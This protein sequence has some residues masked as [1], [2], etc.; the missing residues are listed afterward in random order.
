MKV[1]LPL[2][3]VPSD[4]PSVLQS[5]FNLVPYTSVEY[6]KDPIPPV[7]G[8]DLET[9]P[10]FFCDC[11]H[12]YQSF[13]T[14]RT[15]QTR[16]DDRQCPRRLFNPQ[17]HMGYAQ[18]LT[19]NRPFFEVDISVL[20]LASDDH[21]RYPLAFRQSMPPLR[22]YSKMAIKGAEDEMNTS[23]F[24]YKERWLEYL[25]GYST[26]DILE[27]IKD[28]TPE[29][30]FGPLLRRVARQFLADSC[31]MIKEFNS[32]GLPKLL[33]QT[34]GRETLH[35][36]DH[37]SEESIQTYSMTLHRLIFGVLRQMDEGYS[38]RFR[39]PV[40]HSTQRVPLEGL[41]VGLEDGLSMK[42][43]VVLFEKACFS[44]FAHHK[45]KYATSKHLNQ[46][47]SP[48]ICFFVLQSVQKGGGFK[49]PNIISQYAAHLMFSIRAVMVHRIK[50][51]YDEED[52]G[53]LE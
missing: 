34:T 24:F 35:R 30:P 39:Y 11:G 9:L 33:G 36:F 2:V 43:L 18:R 16:K 53:I 17:S 7:F 25:K 37:L 12:G 4:F 10:M 23:T 14:L 38:H 44:I 3:E 20:R 28:S 22:E 50:A 45:H 29:V 6:S 52:I 41:K 15:H 19:A 46:F 27:A 40:L 32:F 26:E 13:E 42:E 47:F 1:D 21:T 49:R 51:K 31:A 8:I 5:T 48:A